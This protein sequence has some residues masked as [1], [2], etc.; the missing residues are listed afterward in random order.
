MHRKRLKEENVSGKSKGLEF[1]HCNSEDF[2]G[3]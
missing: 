1:I 3:M 2:E